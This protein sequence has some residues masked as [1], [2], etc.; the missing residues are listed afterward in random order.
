M[1]YIGFAIAAAGIFAISILLVKYVS[2]YIIQDSNSL[3]FWSY[4]PTLPFVI[5]IPL[6]QGWQFNWSFILPTIVQALLLSSGV[7]FYLKGLKQTDASVIGPL[8][9][10]QSGFIVILAGLF[11]HEN[12]P[13]AV[14]GYLLLLT[15]GAMFVSVTD[16]TKWR[17]LFQKGVLFI[18]V[19]QLLHAGANITVGFALKNTN[20]WQILF[21]SMVFSS[22]FSITYALAQKTPITWDFSKV[23]W[24]FLRGFLTILGTACLYKAFETNL[25]ISASF[26]LLSSPL[27]F[28]ISLLSAWLMPGLLEKQ[29]LKTY[30]IR[31]FGM[32][33]I[34]I[35]AWN[36]LALR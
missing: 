1:N 32:G 16:K 22:I 29:S 27:V 33:I 17:G 30:L 35:S 12:Y 9:Q 20:S 21:Y 5:F 2:K 18:C 24:L 14:Y 25:A 8:F 23:K 3:F 4:L 10:L 31:T 13:P 15:I 7:H 26:G 11:L 6:W 34:L 28:V 36:I 19:T